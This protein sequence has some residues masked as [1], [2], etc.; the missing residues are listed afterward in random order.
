MMEDSPVLENVLQLPPPG[1]QQ[2]YPGPQHPDRH[3]ALASLVA[4]QRLPRRVAPEAVPKV[5]AAARKLH[6]AATQLS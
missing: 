5:A 4:P 1:Q 6:L 3:Q 2:L